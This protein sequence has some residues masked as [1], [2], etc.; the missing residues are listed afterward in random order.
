MKFLLKFASRSRPHLFQKRVDNWI[1]KSSGKHELYWLCSFDEDDTSMTDPA[2]QA[3][4]VAHKLHV[5]YGP[6]RGKVEAINADMQWM[7]SDVSICVIVSDDMEVLAQ[8]WDC[9]VADAMLAAFPDLNG[10][11]WYHDGRQNRTCTLS[12][13]GKPIYDK[14]G[15]LYYPEYESVYCDNDFHELMQRSGRL[16]FC[17]CKVFKHDW[18]EENNDPLMARNERSEVYAKDKA[19][20]E[21]RRRELGWV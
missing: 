21:R 14:L 18:R 2:M 15:Y 9:I 16:K 12:I 11:L 1:D 17:G 10:A 13:M 19:V 3:W 7:P 5:Y 6:P 4:C 20:W 8:N